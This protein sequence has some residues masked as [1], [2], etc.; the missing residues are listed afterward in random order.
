MD[1]HLREELYVL[2]DEFA[3]IDLFTRGN[4]GQKQLLVEVLIKKIENI[5]IKIY[6]ERGHNMPHIHIDYGGDQNHTAS[7]S[8]HTGERIEGSLNKKY[9]KFVKDWIGNN[10][11]KILQIWSEIQ[12]GDQKKYEETIASIK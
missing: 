9:D 8:I 5:K 11:E 10:R 7:Y 4:N 6:Q 12:S 1:T 3:T 2:Q